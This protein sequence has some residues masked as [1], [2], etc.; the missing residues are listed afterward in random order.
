[1]GIGG[2]SKKGNSILRPTKSM[3]NPSYGFR[4]WGPKSYENYGRNRAGG[5]KENLPGFA[6]FQGILTERVKTQ[7]KGISKEIEGA[8]EKI[9]PF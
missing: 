9:T 4:P 6:H 8:F 5:P 2:I 7:N 1:M 3:K